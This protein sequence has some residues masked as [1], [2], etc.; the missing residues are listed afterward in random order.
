M[1]IL[2]SSLLLSALL[3]LTACEPKGP[4]SDIGDK[5]DEVIDQP[6]APESSALP[7]PSEPE[8]AT[9]SPHP[10][11]AD[12]DN[13]GTEDAN[14]SILGA[15]GIV[16]PASEMATPAPDVIEEQKKQ[17]EE[18]NKAA[19]KEADQRLNEI[20]EKTIDQP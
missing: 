18:A 8:H 9:E 16:D 13:T 11:T 1:R 17:L 2:T 7:L 3:G 6:A 20:L 15:D 14:S 12:P 19:S 5:I 4:A 10:T